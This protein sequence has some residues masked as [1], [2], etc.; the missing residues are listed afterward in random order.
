MALLKEDLARL[1]NETLLALQAAC[2]DRYLTALPLVFQAL[3]TRLE[4]RGQLLQ[5]ERIFSAAARGDVDAALRELPFYP[6]EPKWEKAVYLLIAWLTAEKNMGAARTLHHRLDRNYPFPGPLWIL[7]QRVGHTLGGPD[8][9]L[10][11]LPSNVTEDILKEFLDR[12]GGMQANAEMIDE[13]LVHADRGVQL[14]P[15]YLEGI[16][17]EGLSGA[18]YASAVEAPILVGYAWEHKKEGEQYFQSYLRMHAANPYAEYRKIHLWLILE[19]VLRHPEDEWVKQTLSVLL[20][21]AIGEHGA[22]FRQG[23]PLVLLGLKASNK[24]VKAQA[25]LDQRRQQAVDTASSRSRK[26]RMS[27]TWGED[28][29]TLCALALVYHQIL[30]QEDQ[31][32]KLFRQ[33]INL[34]RGYAGFMVPAYLHLAETML[35]CGWPC[36]DC[37]QSVLKRALATAHKIQD[38]IFCARSTGRVNAM[39]ENWWP[40]SLSEELEGLVATF[41]QNPQAPRFAPRYSIGEDFKYRATAN[42]ESMIK[43][44]SEL[45][46]AVTLGELALALNM[47]VDSLMALNYEAGWK[48]DTIL[49]TNPPTVVNLPDPEFAPLLAARIS[50]EI[51]AGPLFPEKKQILIQKLVP[52][53]ATDPTALDTVLARLLVAA[54]PSEEMWD[55][56]YLYRNE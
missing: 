42:G 15:T 43:I 33:A 17:T 26:H 40:I 4:F 27:D 25:E 34:P 13:Y 39:L 19:A 54:K 36:Q 9:H 37:I 49:L 52:V 21:R 55:E 28:K 8:A 11:D 31:A 24:D 44:P 2:N 47:S 38:P 35:I 46:E 53:A 6:L 16:L 45:K 5:P 1:E 56:L 18:Y 32:E 22:E 30:N 12:A 51:L 7:D 29:R 14:N 41:V 23:L 48:A 3:R 10:E 20:T 50:A